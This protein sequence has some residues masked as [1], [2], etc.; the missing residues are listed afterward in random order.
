MQARCRNI[1]ELSAFGADNSCI[2]SY[3]WFNKVDYIHWLKLR[4]IKGNT[5]LVYNW[6]CLIIHEDAL[7]QTL[8]DVKRV[9]QVCPAGLH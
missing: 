5:C 8:T 6:S 2:I 9:V 3:I 4:Q 1:M 7:L